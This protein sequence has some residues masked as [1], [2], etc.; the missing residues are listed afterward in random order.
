MQTELATS[1]HSGVSTLDIYGT[2]VARRRACPS[3]YDHGTTNCVVRKCS[4]C[5]HGDVSTIAKITVAD[6]Q[7]DCPTARLQ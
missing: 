2:T 1:A 6:T 5:L 3:N 7:C 4:A